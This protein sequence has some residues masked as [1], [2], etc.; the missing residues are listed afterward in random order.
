MPCSSKNGRTFELRKSAAGSAVFIE[1]HL[2]ETHVRERVDA[3]LLVDGS[4]ALDMTDV[5]RVLAH[6]EAWMVGLDLTVSFFV[7]LDLLEG[8]NLRFGEDATVLG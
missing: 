1:V 6:E 8:L 7:F 4:D 5:K 3:G 2:G